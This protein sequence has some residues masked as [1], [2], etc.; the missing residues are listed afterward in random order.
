MELSG[1]PEGRIR[2]EMIATP[3]GAA[4]AGIDRG[5]FEIAFRAGGT[6]GLEITLIC[7]FQG[8]RYIGDKLHFTNVAHADAASTS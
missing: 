5:Y 1:Q 3:H 6:H 4:Y 7:P 8:D 2:F